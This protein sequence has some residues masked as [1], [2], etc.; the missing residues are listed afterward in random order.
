MAPAPLGH[1]QDT[2]HGKLSM[3]HRWHIEMSCEVTDVHHFTVAC[4]WRLCVGSCPKAPGRSAHKRHQ[5]RC[6]GGGAKKQGDLRS[7]WPWRKDAFPL[8]GHEPYECDCGQHQA[9]RCSQARVLRIVEQAQ[10][11]ES[12]ARCYPLQD[13]KSGQEGE[14]KVAQGQIPGYKIQHSTNLEVRCPGGAQCAPWP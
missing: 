14:E 5:D 6:D 8:G 1:W 7:S 4:L 3:R 12:L 10:A 13:S 11:G 2:H 9:Q